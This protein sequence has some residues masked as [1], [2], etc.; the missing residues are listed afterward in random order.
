MKAG[1]RKC[2]GII[3]CGVSDNIE[4]DYQTA[5]QKLYEAGLQQYLDI[6][7]QQLDAY[8]EERS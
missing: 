1:W 7:Q 2:A 8:W 5:I 6:L 3:C 4:E